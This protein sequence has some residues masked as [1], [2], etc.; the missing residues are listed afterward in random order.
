MPPA[1]LGTTSSTS[2][3]ASCPS[4][5]AIGLTT[6]IRFDRWYNFVVGGPVD[7]V[8]DRSRQ[9]LLCKLPHIFDIV[10]RLKSAEHARNTHRS[11]L[12]R[13]AVESASVL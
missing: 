6:V 3:G 1:K 9:P 11:P 10:A 12:M 13:S 8:K 4:D 2:L 5:C 7:V